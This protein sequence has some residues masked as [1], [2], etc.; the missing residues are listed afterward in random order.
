MHG[1]SKTLTEM[2]VVER[3]NL[4]DTVADALEAS[5][6]EVEDDGD[7]RDVANLVCVARTIRGMADDMSAR[8]LH[9]AELLLEQGITMIYQ[10]ENRR[11]SLVH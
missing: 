10:R 3:S 7:P 8:D 2:N 1:I 5:A 9:A 4:L 11:A 6:S